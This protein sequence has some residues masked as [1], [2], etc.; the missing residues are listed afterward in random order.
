MN[1][2]EHLE[3]A[4]TLST[5]TLGLFAA[6]FLLFLK[7]DWKTYGGLT[8]F[9]LCIFFN[10]VSVLWSFL[11]LAPQTARLSQFVDGISGIAL[12]TLAPSLWLY[13]RA[14]TSAHE[15]AYRPRDLLHFL[16]TVLTALVIAASLTLGGEER[17]RIYNGAETPLTPE[18]RAV[19]LSMIGL[20]MVFFG[21]WLI[22][23][24][25]ISRRLFYYRQRLKDVFASTIGREM[26]WIRVIMV[27]FFVYW[28]LSIAQAILDAISDTVLFPEV[29][30]DFLLLFLV[31][32]LALWG[33]R[34]DP[35][36]RAQGLTTYPLDT[37]PPDAAQRYRNSGLTRERQEK[38]ARKI[39]TALETDNLCKNPNLS[40]YVLA[41][42]ISTPP[43]YVTQALNEYLGKSFF[44]MVNELRL[45]A[46]KKAL[47]ET[48]DS[49]LDIAYGAG[50]NSRSVFYSAFKRYEATTPTEYRRRALGDTSV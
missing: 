5:L 26:H 23:W 24:V 4:A 42:H 29:A 17:A 40:L 39:E 20:Q 25:A 22:Y 18:L 1:I 28:T 9:F 36:L 49:V 48:N 7:R 27:L 14:I 46:A 37:A 45:R 6:S 32:L 16:P 13:A 41:D 2:N 44:D 43:H 38:I 34:Q 10:D 21:Q 30:D 15:F 3:V 50:F 31:W 19:I 33:L 12:L 47:L 11:D 35:G 8:V